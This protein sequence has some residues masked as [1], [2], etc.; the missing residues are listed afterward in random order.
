MVVRCVRITDM[1]FSLAP[2][3]KGLCFG[4]VRG[5][6]AVAPFLGADVSPKRA[7][8][9]GGVRVPWPGGLR[10]GLWA[11]G[12]A[13]MQGANGTSGYKGSVLWNDASPARPLGVCET[14]TGADDG[15]W[16]IRTEWASNG[17][18]TTGKPQV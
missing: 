11:A 8:S 14:G 7:G 12:E 6:V 2:Q 3:P 15:I 10:G 18:C 4:Y 5:V 13:S 16:N 9:I 17:L 1:S